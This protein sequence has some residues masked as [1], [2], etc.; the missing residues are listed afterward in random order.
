MGACEEGAVEGGLSPF[1][2]S[3]DEDLLPPQLEAHIDEVLPVLAAGLP[4]LDD[5]HNCNGFLMRG[6]VEE[7]LPALGKAAGVAH[8]QAVL[9]AGDYPEELDALPTVEFHVGD[10]LVVPEGVLGSADVG[11]LGGYREGFEHL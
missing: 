6:D 4:V 1:G 9:L 11:V 7:V 2:L 5:P 8:L 10:V 3:P